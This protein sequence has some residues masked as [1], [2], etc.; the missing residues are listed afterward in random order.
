MWRGS[1]VFLEAPVERA[2]AQVRYLGEYLDGEAL[3][4]GVRAPIST[5]VQVVLWVAGY[6]MFDELRLATVA[7]RSYDQAAG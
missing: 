3:G 5:S 4:G 1:G 7:V 2:A 6:G